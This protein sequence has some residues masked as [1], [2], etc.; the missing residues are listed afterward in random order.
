MFARNGVARSEEVVSVIARCDCRGSFVTAFALT[1]SWPSGAV[2]VDAGCGEMDH[3]E[4]RR[5]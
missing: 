5:T 3:V 1:D 2:M 4:M